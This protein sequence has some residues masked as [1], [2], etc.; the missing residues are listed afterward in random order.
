MD[1]REEYEQLKRKNRNRLIG[2]IVLVAA[3][4][5]ILLAVTDKKTPPTQPEVKIAGKTQPVEKPADLPPPTDTQP[6]KP[7]A[8]PIIIDTVAQ[9]ELPSDPVIDTPVEPKVEPKPAQPV[10]K[11]EKK[12]ATKPVKPAEK[13][14][15]TPEKPAK[16]PEKPA[17]PSPQDILEGKASGNYFVQMGAFKTQAQ[18]D[19]QRAK[20]AQVGISSQIQQGKDKNGNTVYRVRS[21]ALSKAEAE[22]I[23]NT[24]KTHKFDAMIV[25]Q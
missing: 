9:P 15:K 1:T 23:R 11:T 17:K 25:S 5:L 12:P 6:E 18:A 22:K 13:P 19:T 7:A 8:E 24:A 20:L 14:Q 21:G 3:I 2:A 16:Q 10:P 4:A